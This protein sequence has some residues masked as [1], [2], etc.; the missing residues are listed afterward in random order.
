[1][2]M[3]SSSSS[4]SSS[5]SCS[6][7]LL[8]LFALLLLSPS[9]IYLLT[10]SVLPDAG[11]RRARV[12]A[13]ICWRYLRSSYFGRRILYTTTSWKPFQRLQSA[14]IETKAFLHNPP[15]VEVV[16][17]KIVLPNITTVTSQHSEHLAAMHADTCPCARM[18]I[19]IGTSRC[20]YSRPPSL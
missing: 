10:P 19:V 20:P 3:M 11:G 14:R 2:I 6:I 15:W 18:P 5:S 1:M 16:V 8:S 7:L 9:I 17:Y 12:C 13:R 4:S